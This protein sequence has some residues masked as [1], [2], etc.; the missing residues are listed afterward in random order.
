M[1]QNYAEQVTNTRLHSSADTGSSTDAGAGPARQLTARQ[2]T[3]P[4]IAPFALGKELLQERLARKF[5]VAGPERSRMPGWQEAVVMS[6]HCQCMGSPDRKRLAVLR[7]GHDGLRENLS[8][9]TACHR[10]T[11]YQRR[12]DGAKSRRDAAGSPAQVSPFRVA[13]SRV[14]SMPCSHQ[15][16][17]A[18]GAGPDTCTLPACSVRRGF[19]P[20]KRLRAHWRFADR[21]RWLGCA[22]T[23]RPTRRVPKELKGL[24][25]M[26]GIQSSQFIS[27]FLLEDTLESAATSNTHLDLGQHVRLREQPERF[28]CKLDKSCE[29]EHQQGAAIAWDVWLRSGGSATDAPSPCHV[30][31]PMR[32][33]TKFEQ[34]YSSLSEPLK[35]FR[36]SCSSKP[37]HMSLPEAEERSTPTTS[38]ASTGDRRRDLPWSAHAQLQNVRA[39][40]AF[41]TQRK[42]GSAS[43]GSVSVSP[44]ISEIAQRCPRLLAAQHCL[45]HCFSAQKQYG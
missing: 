18:F 20:R 31:M 41:P 28:R 39:T 11:A 36:S 21:R 5:A 34:D 38:S 3:A 17:A 40:A 2:L 25:R 8:P 42:L 6:G 7:L 19:V 26:M 15:T 10:G 23:R 29:S 30:H 4:R 16:I 33:H 37:R 32:A 14:N 13:R 12:L 35:A 43:C 1:R 22:H 27:H 44:Q 45:A 9:K 24:K